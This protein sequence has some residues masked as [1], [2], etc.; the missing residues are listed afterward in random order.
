MLKEEDK[1]YFINCFRNYV[2]NANKEFSRK[3]CPSI[4]EILNDFLE[5]HHDVLQ[6]VENQ[7]LQKSYIAQLNAM[8]IFIKNN[9]FNKSSFAK[10]LSILLKEIMSYGKE[11]TDKKDKSVSNDKSWISHSLYNYCVALLK[12]LN[13]DNLYE[14]IINV[15]CTCTTYSEFDM[16]VEALI[17]ELIFDGYSL[18]Y[19][20]EWY[21]NTSVLYKKDNSMN[22][23]DFIKSFI[24]LK[25]DEQEF[26]VF[27]TIKNDNIN[28]VQHWKIDYELEI[29]FVDKKDI[30]EEIS[31]HLQFNSTNRAIKVCIKRSDTHSAAFKVVDTLNDYL[32]IINLVNNSNT[33]SINEKVVVKYAD[34]YKIEKLNITLNDAKFLL[35]NIDKREKYDLED[36]TQYRDNI[37]RSNIKTGEITS[38]ERSLNILK[39]N[40][41]YNQQN[42]LIELWSILEY[43]LSYYSSNSIISKAKDIIPKMMCL[44]L[45]KEKLNIFWNLLLKSHNRRE[46]ANEFITKS[47]VVDSDEKYDVSKL[48]A[49]IQ[50]YS[51]NLNGSLGYHE[52]IINRRYCEL[53]SI[54]SG[55]L[56][57]EKL[58][59]DT[60]KMIES[61]VVRIYRT[62]NIIVHSGNQTQT[63]ILLKNVRLTQYLSNLVGVLLHYKRKNTEHSIQEIL[64]SIPVTYENYLGM[65]GELK[66]SN[67]DN[68]CEELL[69]EIFKPHYLF[70]S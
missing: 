21:T 39:N 45:L 53:G 5:L 55:G 66:K 16:C 49:N 18:I 25:K 40:T 30:T 22:Y 31:K 70:L 65:V 44:Y 6:S 20:K 24:A 48:I 32:L 54:I 56:N 38:I 23:D 27:L 19:L 42:R 67:H 3:H 63:N 52:V 17:N 33:F 35:S 36:F 37:Y 14:E 62:R 11:Q 4:R 58:I 26:E 57:L 50:S 47:L 13:S 34:N 12:K 59:K 28:T 29:T 51:T 10:D 8:E 61:D 43:L 7:K 2:N 41:P 15:F 64:Y 1:I 46:L 60:H 9:I 68:V 69:V